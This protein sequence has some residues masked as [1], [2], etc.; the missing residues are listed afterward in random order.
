MRNFCQHEASSRMAYG[1]W[2]WVMRVLGNWRMRSDL[3]AIQKFND[4]QLRDIG[5]MREDLAFL[6]SRPLTSDM[7]WELERQQLLSR[8]G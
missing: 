8:R 3:R 4:Y 7:C 1:R 5:L 2:T 6:L